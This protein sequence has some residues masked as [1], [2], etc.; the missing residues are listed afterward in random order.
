VVP[1]TENYDVHLH[2]NGELVAVLGL[3]EWEQLSATQWA[4]EDAL[5]VAEGLLEYGS[6][7]EEVDEA[8]KREEKNEAAEKSRK[9]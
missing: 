3:D 8:L 9:P 1:K 7:I 4:L 6:N 2:H 5:E